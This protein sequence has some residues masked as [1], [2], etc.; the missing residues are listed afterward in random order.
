M[1]KNRPRLKKKSA[2]A[3]ELKRKNG[4][5]ESV[6][7]PKKLKPLLLRKERRLS[8]PSVILRRLRLV[9]K[10]NLRFKNWPR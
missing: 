6:K 10:K 8:K 4:S 9:R 3:K 1:L 5:S 2:N 7:K